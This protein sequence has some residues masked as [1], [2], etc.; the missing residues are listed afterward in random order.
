MKRVTVVSNNILS[1]GYDEQDLI[2][3]IEFKGGSIYQY[4]E[5]PLKVFNELMT[6]ESHGKYFANYIQKGNYKYKKVK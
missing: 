3:E 1:I 5:I 2:L 4:L 6:A